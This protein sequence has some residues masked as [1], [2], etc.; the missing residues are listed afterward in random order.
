[1]Y[2]VLITILALI[3][4]FIGA[5][6]HD[7]ELMVKNSS[8]AEAWFTIEGGQVRYL[9]AQGSTSVQYPSPRTL[10]IEYAGYHI[11]SGSIMMDMNLSDGGYLSLE[12]SCGALKFYNSSGSDI[13][14]LRISPSSQNNWSHNLL[15]YY[16]PKHSSEIISLKSGFYDLKIRDSSNCYHYVSAQEILLDTTKSYVFT[17]Y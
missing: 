7:S 11:L 16:L 4:L 1:M 6:F 12:P 10:V 15:Q 5:C 14:E 3:M 17:G 2:K 8:N 9:P 13:R